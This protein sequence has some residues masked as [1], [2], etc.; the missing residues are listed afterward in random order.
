VKGF[1]KFQ[2][3][4]QHDQMD[5]GP[6]CLRMICRYYGKDLPLQKLREFSSITREGVSLKGISE[7]AEKIGFRTI[8]VKLTFDQLDKEAILPCILYWN[9]QHFV[10]LPPQNYNSKKNDQR[11]LIADPGHGM[12]KVSRSTFDDC[13]L[14][15]ETGSGI[16]LLLEPTPSFFMLEDEKA[17]QSRLIFL[18]K[19]LKP[20]RKLLIQ[21]VAGIFI[22]SILSLIA[23]F[24]TQSIVDYGI[25]QKDLNF[26]SLILI[27]QLILFAGSTA[28]EIIR[29]WLLLH[30]S[31]RVN[32]AILSNF[33]I[34]LMQLPIRFF[35]TRQVGD[36]TQRVNDHTR[37][38]HFLSNTSLN[39]L[40]SIVNLFVFLIV[41]VAYSIPI[42]LIFITG[43]V[44]AV[45]WMLFFMKRRKELDYEKFQKMTD[46]QNNIYEI[47]TG[48]QEIKLNDGETIHRWGWENVQSQL[49]NINLKS[50]G[51]ES[52]QLIG[53]SFL[54]QLKNILI[55]FIAARE[56]IGDHIT[57]GMMLSI[58]Y[59]TGQLN[60]P[61][62]Q[63]IVFFRG[64]QDARISLERLSE[65]HL[66]E[67]EEKDSELKNDDELSS[68]I[69]QDAP[70]RGS[71]RMRNVSFRFGGESSPFILKNVSLDIPFGKTTAIVGESGSGKT[72][73]IK[74]L[75]KFY[76]PYEGDIC[77]GS[78]SLSR[79]SP[80]WWRNK[81]GVV[82]SDGYI[83]SNSIA[84]NITIHD[85]I[86]KERLSFA[87]QLSNLQSFIDD[88][89]L[90]VDTKIGKSGNGISSGQGQ[91]ILLA[92]AVYKDP[93]FLFF[94]EAT[95]TLDAKNE[96]EII[97]N[98]NSFLIKR[99]VVVIA[100]RLSTV[101][102]ADQI[103][104]MEKGQIIESGNHDSLIRRKGKYY[105]LIESQ[106][107]LSN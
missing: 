30:I 9:K 80:K 58:A 10:V 15:K 8:G 100:H 14:N 34:K 44:L 33:L 77:I 82:M 64:A 73:L 61:I 91:R 94:D 92:R 29:N 66:K 19:Y 6:T 53:T 83:F 99:T 25:N 85:K 35:D 65:I 5:C 21:L 43:S 72:T 107:E 67:N 2:V 20:Y 48:M 55:T 4:H 18:F 32:I 24:L 40:F 101:K 88:L 105:Q 1:K 93:E 3:Y 70:E 54:N 12:V 42:F 87:I 46:S 78:N 60:S 47:I 41:L 71:I 106:L 13:W 28:I 63:L 50:M 90:G 49:F 74:L 51:V 89:P 59:I 98:L 7:A 56:V 96:R 97:E 81:C 31:S 79:I 23:P 45:V 86:D 52:I 84:R 27:A 76:E 68:T 62:D 38:E 16:V 26:V 104:V 103:I 36:I 11:I 95:S 22:T 17:E 102:H 69:R 75:L 37:I 57:L 39:T